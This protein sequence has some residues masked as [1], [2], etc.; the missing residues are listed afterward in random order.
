MA[1]GFE[2]ER[3]RLVER[4]VE[5]G[6]VR[7]RAVAEAL[8]RV[9]RE[10]FLPPQVREYAY[11]DMPLPIGYGQ[12]ISAPHMVAMMCEYA[13]LEEGMYVLEVGTGSG[14]HAAVIAEIVGPEGHVYSVERIPELAMF[15]KRNLE[16]TGYGERVT[17]IIGDGSRGFEPAAPY[18]AIIVTAA[19][20]SIP[21]PL[22]EQL[23]VGGRLVIP[24]GPR[25][26]QVL[27]VCTR[28]E[29]GVVVEKTVPCVFVPLVG[30]YGWRDEY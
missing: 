6:V 25:Y 29:K 10:E 9:P 27:Y 4:L 26:E 15:A 2:E 8:M 21:R 3:R 18:D 19:A 5:E 12:T 28:T 7:S 17:I 13:E 1:E 20:P 24:V 11:S 22:V 16:R 14:Y 23:R 30:E